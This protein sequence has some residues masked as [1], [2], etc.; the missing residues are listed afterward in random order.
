MDI[1]TRNL[2]KT[3]RAEETLRD[4]I[5]ESVVFEHFA[6]F[7]VLSKEYSEE[8]NLDD[9]H[10][11]EGGDMGIDGIGILVNGNLIKDIDEINDL[12]TSNKY[13]EAEFIF[14]QSKTSSTFD[15]G[16]I[17]NF[18][19]G[20]RDIFNAD[21]AIPKNQKIKDKIYLINAIYEKPALFK[22]GNPNLKMYYVSTGKWNND[23]H[24]LAKINADVS[25]LENMNIFKGVTF[26]P[27]DA[28]NIQK[29]YN[30]AKNSVS[31]T[32]DFE[33]KVTI[34]EIQGIKEAYLGI[35]PVTEILKLLT[36]D[37]GIMLRG[38]FYDN[39]RDFQGDNEV[40][41]EIEQTIKSP[42]KDLFVLL[43]NGVTVVADG[44]NKTGNKF[45]I[46][47]FQV[48][49]GCQTSHVLYNN[50]DELTSNMQVPVRI[51]VSDN[52]DIKNKIIKATNR[53]TPVKSEDLIALTDFQKLLEKYY[54]S[55]PE[56]HRLYYE[57]RSQQ[58][59]STTGIEKIR[60][61]TVSSQIRSFASMFL[62]EPHLAGRYYGTLLTTVKDDIFS[63]NHKPIA[64]YVSAYANHKLDSLLR[65]KQIDE[66]YRPFKYI[67][68]M[69]LRL[70]LG[71]ITMPNMTSKDFEKY[72][73]EIQ[74]VIWDNTAVLQSFI[75][76]CTLLDQVLNGDYDRA[77]AKTSRFVKAITT[78]VTK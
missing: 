75:E 16:D 70:K 44:L 7:C 42:D 30:Y 13:I 73:H 74:S 50:K 3:F 53:Q 59:R 52:D 19:F 31:Q 9:I 57:R 43:N 11:G 18:L 12:A 67:M 32:I 6:N 21:S 40:N 77:I 22:R 26:N 64:Y 56:E 45:R 54:D 5:S 17:G 61:V 41:I 46:E 10:T 35:L 39:V 49:N 24:L 36:D 34:P 69:A 27:V 62:N 15:G 8:F 72:C 58:Y 78:E 60:I 76:V 55:Q 14:I 47:G 33:N 2:L 4:D 1:V 68:L 37:D 28:I 63:K 25:L 65:K 48:V 20:V 38:L 29:L 51:I 23:Q 71:G 66:K